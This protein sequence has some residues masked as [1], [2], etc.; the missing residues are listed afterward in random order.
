MIIW[1][2]SKWTSTIYKCK[3]KKTIL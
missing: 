2:S 3:L 1:P